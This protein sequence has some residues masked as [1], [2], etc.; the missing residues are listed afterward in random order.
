MLVCKLNFSW[1]RLDGITWWR[2]TNSLL[3][4]R[5][6]YKQLTPFKSFLTY[7]FFGSRNEHK[8]LPKIWRAKSNNNFN[9][10]LKYGLWAMIC[11]QKTC[12]NYHAGHNLRWSSFYSRFHSRCIHVLVS[13]GFYRLDTNKFH[14]FSMIFTASV[15][16]RLYDVPFPLQ[17]SYGPSAQLQCYKQPHNWC[18][19]S[20][21]FHYLK[22]LIQ[23]IVD[24]HKKPL[25][26]QLITKFSLR[27][28]TRLNRQ[29]F[30]PNSIFHT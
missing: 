17:P 4:T 15:F 21:H 16:F 6:W 28:I 9:K 2:V 14:E 23:T 30:Y 11:T 29:C 27:N 20:S 19:P 26:F 1:Y 18:N 25:F 22:Q 10:T 5:F 13:Q 8:T 12:F 3:M 24:G 7:R